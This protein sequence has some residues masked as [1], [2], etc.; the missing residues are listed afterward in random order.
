MILKIMTGSDSYR[1]IDNIKSIEYSF[2]PTELNKFE[3]F[4]SYW[5]KLPRDFTETIFFQ[6]IITDREEAF[7][8][9][10]FNEML[11]QKNNG[12][13]QKIIFDT[14]AY[15]CNDNGKTLE[16]IHSTVN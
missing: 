2:R 4:N 16:I 6:T 9:I 1:L 5:S 10:K 12:E 8:P 7:S 13:Y 3:D 11:F 14:S 15:I